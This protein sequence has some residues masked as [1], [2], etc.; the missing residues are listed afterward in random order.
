MPD[1]AT[2]WRVAV[3]LL[4]RPRHSS[5]ELKGESASSL[6]DL[7]E[8]FFRDRLCHNYS[9]MTVRLPNFL[10]NWLKSERAETPVEASGTTDIVL[11]CLPNEVS[12]TCSVSAASNL[13]ALVD[14]TI[15]KTENE[16]ILLLLIG[17]LIGLSDTLG[18]GQVL[19]K[20]VSHSVNGGTQAKGGSRNENFKHVKSGSDFKH[21]EKKLE[22]VI[23]KKQLLQSFIR[24]AGVSEEEVMAT[25]RDHVTDEAFRPFM[26]LKDPEKC[27][28]LF[29]RTHTPAVIG[30]KRC[31][32][33]S[34]S[35]VTMKEFLQAIAGNSQGWILTSVRWIR[36]EDLPAQLK[37]LSLVD[38][39][40]GLD[41]RRSSQDIDQEQVR[42]Q[43]QEPE[44]D[45]GDNTLGAFDED[46]I[47][48]PDLLQTLGL[49]APHSEKAPKEGFYFYNSSGD[50]RDS[51]DSWNVAFLRNQ[52][53]THIHGS[54][55]WMDAHNLLSSFQ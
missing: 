39:K 19:P 11:N 24:P 18:D 31:I 49:R 15:G 48:T 55:F 44:T 37:L 4:L 25:H 17:P 45:L 21:L 42:D 43:E 40:F 13:C 47:G 7:R 5:S 50:G 8:E 3:R 52:E 12:G 30:S 41:P 16:K 28:E 14:R 6:R 53:R 46:M 54:W 33:L 1:L 27:G 29:P 34:N 38:L 36:E 10:R 32:S 20:I 2:K 22:E 35:V 51:G 9:T 23:Q 26:T